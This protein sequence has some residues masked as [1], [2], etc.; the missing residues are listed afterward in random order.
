M[1]VVGQDGATIAT[2][3]AVTVA[4]LLEAISEGAVAAGG[5]RIRV[6]H[7][8]IGDGVNTNENAAKRILSYFWS[9]ANSPIAVKYFFWLSSS[10]AHT[11][12]TW[13]RSSR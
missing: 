3:I 2:S 6:I 12:A 7:A 4:N 11:R 10:A 5:K 8:L 1:S 13:S 9:V